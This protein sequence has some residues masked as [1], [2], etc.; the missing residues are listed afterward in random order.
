MHTNVILIGMPG[1]GKST[2][3]VLLA[4]QLQMDYA[5]TDILIQRREG[6]RLQEIIAAVGLDGFCDVEARHI[7]ALRLRHTVIAT[8]GSVVYRGAAMAHLQA[9]GRIAY[10]ETPPPVLAQRLG[11][12][13]VRGVVLRPGQ[14]LEDLY[15]ER[16]ALYRRFAD[17]TVA[18]D[19][20]SAEQVNRKLAGMLV[21]RETCNDANTC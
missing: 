17:L 10:L 14:G 6:R 8:G 18:C 2:V 21:R 3:G 11:D 15:R 12:L 7:L 4:K 5:D 9:M 13:A 16:D 20:L 1:A 19:A